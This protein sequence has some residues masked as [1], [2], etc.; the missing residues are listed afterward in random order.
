M[1][2]I[3]VSARKICASLAILVLLSTAPYLYGISEP[4]H[5]ESFEPL[6]IPGPVAL[7]TSP[8]DQGDAI[9]VTQRIMNYWFSSGIKSYSLTRSS[10]TKSN[11]LQYLNEEFTPPDD[12]L[13]YWNNI[14]HGDKYGLYFY[15]GKMYYYEFENK[16][17]IT[18]SI[19]FINSCYS[20]ENPLKNSM[21]S[22]HP[23]VYIGATT[24]LPQYTSENACGN[25]W[26]YYIKDGMSPSQALEQAME[27]YGLEGYFG[28]YEEN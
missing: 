28:L 23:D 25:F 27:D 21:V 12:E 7:A 15:D 14:G 6:Y 18:N 17:G 4:T 26:K 19:I 1:K 22:N 8:T 11:V 2:A 16:S 13:I 10:S 9:S 20:F 24:A 5:K 3:I